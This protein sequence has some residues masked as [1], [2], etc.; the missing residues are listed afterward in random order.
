MSDCI[1]TNLYD[2]RT[3]VLELSTAIETDAAQVATSVTTNAV[4]VLICVVLV[5]PKEL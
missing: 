3:Q 1:S 4:M 5:L 2:S